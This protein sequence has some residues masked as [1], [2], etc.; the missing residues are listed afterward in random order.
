MPV[1]YGMLNYDEHI[2]MGSVTMIDLKLWKQVPNHENL[3]HLSDDAKSILIRSMQEEYEYRRNEGQFIIS[4]D[5]MGKPS[6]VIKF[7]KLD[8]LRM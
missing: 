1:K 3:G 2:F 5:I 6:D 4:S 8:A 7:E